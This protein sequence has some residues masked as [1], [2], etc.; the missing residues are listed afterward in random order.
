MELT[1]SLYESLKGC[2]KRLE[3]DAYVFCDSCG[4]SPQNFK[5]SALLHLLILEIQL[6]CAEFP[7]KIRES[8]D[9]LNNKS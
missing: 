8:I 9:A 5:I 7:V 3:F 2:T 1:L 4:E 6:W